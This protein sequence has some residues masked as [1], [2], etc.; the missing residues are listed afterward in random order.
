[1]KIFFLLNLFFF[2]TVSPAY[3]KYTQIVKSRLTVLKN[4]DGNSEKIGKKNILKKTQ[5][6]VLKKISSDLFEGD[7]A[8]F[9]CEKNRNI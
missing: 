1:M 4:K 3:S 8:F 2:C 5:S 6:S 7:T 9:S